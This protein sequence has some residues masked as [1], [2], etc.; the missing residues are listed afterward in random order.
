MNAL[1]RTAARTATLVDAAGSRTRR[2]HRTLAQ[3]VHVPA[4]GRRCHA[5][6]GARIGGTDAVANRGR[7]H[8]NTFRGVAGRGCGESVVAS[9]AAGIIGRARRSAAGR[10]GA[11]LS[12]VIDLKW[13][14]IREWGC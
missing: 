13:R 12:V 5:R 8:T 7:S 6:G 14:D 9:K 10:I 1:E 2:A 11:L 3:R 4:A